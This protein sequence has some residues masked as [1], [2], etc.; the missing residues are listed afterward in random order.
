MD[1]EHRQPET[2]GGSWSLTP[3]LV[4]GLANLAD[5]LAPTPAPFVTQH[6]A[7]LISRSIGT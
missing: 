6:S 1:K 2:G 5:A 4:A 7:N 3:G